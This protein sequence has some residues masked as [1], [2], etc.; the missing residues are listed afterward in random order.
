MLVAT[1]SK[2]TEAAMK[3]ANDAFAPI[4][5]RVNIA[6]EKLAKVA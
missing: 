5:G 6:A 1:S 2:N 4:T 3:L